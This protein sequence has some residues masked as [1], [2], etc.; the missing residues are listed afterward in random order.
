M[1]PIMSERS[2]A[3]GC[4]PRLVSAPPWLQPRAGYVH[5][6]FCAHHCGYCDFAVA[7]GRDHL[8]DRYLNAL[9]AELSTLQTP[10][11]V[12]TLFL[13]GGTP[14]HLD[15]KQLERLLEHLL[16]WLPLQVGG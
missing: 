10:Q 11:P 8:I 5:V 1:Q 4:S 15:A 6:P 7:A 9:A 2:I 16:R 13:G 12:Q 14:T 3:A